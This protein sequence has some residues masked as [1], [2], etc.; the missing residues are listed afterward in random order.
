[1]AVDP[2][3]EPSRPNGRVS[4]HGL[5]PAG[6]S[7]APPVLDMVFD[8]ST[9]DTLRAKVRASATKAGFADDRIADVVLAVHELAANAVRHGG[10]EGQLRM[11]NQAGALHCQVDDGDIAAAGPDSTPDQIL[12]NSLPC[13]PGHGLWVV[14]QVADRMQS[15]SG[16]HGTSVMIAFDHG[17]LPQP[18]PTPAA[19]FRWQTTRVASRS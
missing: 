14:R 6:T 17:S 18:A 7:A 5:Q 13:Q 15:L 12:T 11:W 1:M 16:S 8:A 19:P 10:G 4:R 3:D 2:R 9:L